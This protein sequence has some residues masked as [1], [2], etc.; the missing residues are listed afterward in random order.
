MNELLEE[1]DRQIDQKQ[2]GLVEL[3]R[4]M[5]VTI[6][7]LKTRLSQQDMADVEALLK[8]LE[9]HHLMHKTLLRLK[10]ERLSQDADKQATVARVFGNN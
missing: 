6:D 9:A 7:D 10:K 5:R 1:L 2:K 3:D 8:L 4:Q